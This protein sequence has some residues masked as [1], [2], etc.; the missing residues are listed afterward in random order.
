MSSNTHLFPPG[1]S[2]VTLLLYIY[3]YIYKS[4]ILSV[5]PS[6]RPSVCLFPFHAKTTEPIGLKFSGNISA[7]FKK[8]IG[9]TRGL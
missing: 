6:V 2:R 4:V 3:I 1:R 9:S 7:L 5:R 8:I